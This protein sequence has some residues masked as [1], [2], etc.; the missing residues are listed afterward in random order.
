M[1]NAKSLRDRQFNVHIYVD[2][3]TYQPTAI[4]AQMRR[5]Y[6]RGKDPQPNEKKKKP[7]KKNTEQTSVREHDSEQSQKEDNLTH[8][9]SRIT[10]ARC[11]CVGE[12]L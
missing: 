9:F 1:F 5:T 3:Y 7:T 8:P 2:I 4:G 11:A 12:T 6:K 10:T